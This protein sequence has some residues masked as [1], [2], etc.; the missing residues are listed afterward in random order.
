MGCQTSKAVSHPAP[1][2][3]LMQKPTVHDK[4]P[5]PEPPQSQSMVAAWDPGNPIAAYVAPGACVFGEEW[6]AAPLVSKVAISHDTRIFTFGLDEDKPLGLSTCACLLMKGVDGPRDAEGNPVVRPYTPVSTNAMLGQF[7]L[8][9]KVYSDGKMSQYLDALEV[10]KPMHFKHVGGNV[11]IQY[12]FSGKKAI[13]MIA[14]GTGITPMIQA[15]HCVL[16]TNEDTSKV[17]VLY[18]SKTSNEILA[19]ETLDAWT[20]SCAD[21]FHVTHV[22]SR[23]PTEGSS[24]TGARGHITREMIEANFPPPESDCLIFVCGPQPLYT[25]FS[26]PR[27]PPGAPPSELAGILKEIG[28]KTEQVIKF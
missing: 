28:Y 26:G 24:W 27:D 22:L 9:V 19:K 16:G 25:A 14:G 17:S 12:P 15:L 5:T 18:A 7:E 13:G 2:K 6:A 1:K 23:E 21:R 10:G 4:K 20:A 11:K 8:M 3:T